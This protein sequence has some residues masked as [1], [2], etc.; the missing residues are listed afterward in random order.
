MANP[1]IMID[2][3]TLSAPTLSRPE[4]LRLAHA[5]AQGLR[6][7]PMDALRNGELGDLRIRLEAGSGQGVERL[8]QQIVQRIRQRLT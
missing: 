2:R 5:V 1:T 3:L 7:L 8:A 6:E 4:A